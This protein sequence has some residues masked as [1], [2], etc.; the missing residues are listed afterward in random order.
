MSDSEGDYIPWSQQVRLYNYRIP[1]YDDRM[2][3][4][5]NDV[6]EPPPWD[7]SW[8]VHSVFTL[9]NLTWETMPVPGKDDTPY[10]HIAMWREQTETAQQSFDRFV[11]D[12]V[13]FINQEEESCH[14]YSNGTR[15]MRVPVS[16]YD[17]DGAVVQNPSGVVDLWWGSYTRY[18][19]YAHL[20]DV[21]K[22]AKVHMFKLQPSGK[23]E[24]NPHISIA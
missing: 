8:P 12:T 18:W 23:W 15:M 17:K 21:N 20:K 16:V 7:H 6:L 9:T 14:R 10:I 4:F 1:T 11:A 19:C 5:M 13:E 24:A 2:A 3:A 22:V